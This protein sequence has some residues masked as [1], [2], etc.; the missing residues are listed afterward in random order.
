MIK[1]YNLIK[2]PILLVSNY[3]NNDT[4][5]AREE[6]KDLCINMENKYNYIYYL[7]LTI[8]NKEYLLDNNHYSNEGFKYIDNKLYEKIKNIDI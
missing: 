4:I 5:P 1:T 8:K 2:K 7:N 6:M 3:I